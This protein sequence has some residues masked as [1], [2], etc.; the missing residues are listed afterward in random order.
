MIRSIQ[1][2]IKKEKSVVSEGQILAYKPNIS[3]EVFA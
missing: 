1:K 3:L 2:K